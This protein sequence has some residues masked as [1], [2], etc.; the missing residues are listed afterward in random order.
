MA[1]LPEEISNGTKKLKSGHQTKK[2]Y[3]QTGFLCDVF[4]PEKSKLLQSPLI[5]GC[6][7]GGCT[8]TT[9]VAVSNT[10]RHDGVLSYN[11]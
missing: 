8:G 7:I 1:R 6:R 11:K 10:D 9:S 5:Y 3:V 2:C 4:L